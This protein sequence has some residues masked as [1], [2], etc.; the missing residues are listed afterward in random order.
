MRQAQNLAPESLNR[1][2][3]ALLRGP[4]SV[5]LLVCAVYSG[6]TARPAR[7]NPKHVRF[8]L[9]PHRPGRLPKGPFRVH[10]V[11][12]SCPFRFVSSGDEMDTKST[13]TLVKFQREIHK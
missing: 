1:R 12:I 8:E 2:R 5:C 10:S 13:W 11:S 4:S 6:P 9:E 7:T 3:H